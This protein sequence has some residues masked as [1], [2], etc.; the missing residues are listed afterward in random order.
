MD[1]ASQ[2]ENGSYG[3]W[4][5]LLAIVVAVYLF[6]VSFTKYPATMPLR[7][8]F[9]AVLC[10]TGLQ[11]VTHRKGSGRSK[12]RTRLL[13]SLALA[14]HALASIILDKHGDN[15]LSVGILAIATGNLF[16]LGIVQSFLDDNRRLRNKKKKLRTIILLSFF[17]ALYFTPLAFRELFFCDV[18]LALTLA[19]CFFSMVLVFLFWIA[20]YEAAIYGRSWWLVFG[21]MVCFVVSVVLFA[22]WWL[23]GGGD[24]FP[25]H[26]ASMMVA[27]VFSQVLITDGIVCLSEETRDRLPFPEREDA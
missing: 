14:F 22:N 25:Y 5:K 15:N 8:L 11:R 1:Q 23:V 16:Y 20:L 24:W 10:L 2:T 17:P 21:G 9:L 27:Y 26:K 3:L 13:Y 18:D 6:V 4:S 7:L 19:V 12:H